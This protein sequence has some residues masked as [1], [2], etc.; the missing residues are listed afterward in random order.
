MRRGPRPTYSR[1]TMEQ[2]YQSGLSDRE[3]SRQIGCSPPVISRWRAE[4][5]LPRNF[6]PCGPGIRQDGGGHRMLYDHAA[7]LR[8]YNA[9]LSDA[10]ISRA[11]KI[12]KTN[13]RR[14]RN[15]EGLPAHAN[16][17]RWRQGGRQ[18]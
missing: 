12:P 14:W 4:R 1:T 17:R 2:L 10:E 6:P 8:L 3:I 16:I 7:L 11:S 13:V 5:N 9:G 18:H 15:R